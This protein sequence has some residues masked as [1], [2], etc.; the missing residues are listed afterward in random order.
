[1]TVY[2]VGIIDAGKLPMFATML[3][4]YWAVFML[5]SSIQSFRLSN[6]VTNESEFI[7]LIQTIR[8]F[9]KVTNAPA[10]TTRE[11]ESSKTS[12]VV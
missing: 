2:I 8:M 9:K 11:S 12:E 6:K 5:F 4:S 7:D 10:P 1:M 3:G